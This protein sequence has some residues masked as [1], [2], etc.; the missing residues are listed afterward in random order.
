MPKSEQSPATPTRRSRVRTPSS[1]TMRQ[2]TLADAYRG[3]DGVF[4][5]LPL[6]G[7]T[8]T[9]AGYAH[10]VLAAARVTRPSRFVISTSGTV[11]R[12][13]TSPLAGPNTP[14]LSELVDGLRA[15]GIAV[16]VLTPRLFLENLLLP[17]VLSG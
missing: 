10:N 15:E 8:E 5:H 4:F 11:T 9:L 3:V 14:V 2:P 17:T 16:T 7:D 1:R 6:A 13:A 12:D